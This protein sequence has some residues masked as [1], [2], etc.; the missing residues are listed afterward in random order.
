M[1]GYGGHFWQTKAWLAAELKGCTLHSEPLFK[2][3]MNP[4]TLLAVQSF[5]NPR[6]ESMWLF[7]SPTHKWNKEEIT[8]F[9]WRFYS[10]CANSQK[11]E[12]DIDEEICFGDSQSLSTPNEVESKQIEKPMS[13]KHSKNVADKDD[14]TNML[15]TQNLK[16]SFQ[17]ADNSMIETNNLKWNFNTFNN[18]SISFGGT[19]F[20]KFKMDIDPYGQ[21]GFA[22]ADFVFAGDEVS[23]N[24]G[25]TK[26]VELEQTEN[27]IK[28]IK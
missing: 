19:P 14:Q 20:K 5:T 17:R 8:N 4:Q 23:R 3:D 22:D 9:K 26:L 28:M 2:L 15:K 18:S 6:Y 24:G 11:M 10:L 27:E 1:E 21:I 12:M 16:W 7:A 13:V 25:E